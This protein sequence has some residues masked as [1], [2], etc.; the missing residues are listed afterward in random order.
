MIR[1]FSFQ[2][3]SFMSLYIEYPSFASCWVCNSMMEEAKTVI[4]RFNLI[5]LYTYV[6]IYIYS[7]YIYIERERDWKPLKW[8]CLK[9]AISQNHLFPILEDNLGSPMPTIAIGFSKTEAWKITS[10]PPAINSIILWVAGPF[11]PLRDSKLLPG[12]GAP[13]RRVSC[14]IWQQQAAGPSPLC[15]PF[16]A[17]SQSLPRS[18]LALP[19]NPSVNLSWS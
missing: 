9:F 11:P 10:Y 17:S 5:Y 3:I 4:K 18:L 16:R 19:W 13:Q 14:S 7:I 12:A 15:P 6:C 8:R 1:V 2:C